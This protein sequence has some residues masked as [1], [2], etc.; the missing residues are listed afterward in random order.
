[1]YRINF[2]AHGIKHGGFINWY[3][4]V[5]YGLLENK[6]ILRNMYRLGRKASIPGYQLNDRGLV[7]CKVGVI[8]PQPFSI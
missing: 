3:V 1:M 8:R 4:G 6:Q 2:S 5:G 7:E